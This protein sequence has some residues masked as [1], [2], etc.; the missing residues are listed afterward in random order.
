MVPALHRKRRTGAGALES[1]FAHELTHVAQDRYW[2]Q[3]ASVDEE[4]QLQVRLGDRDRRDL[5]PLGRVI[6]GHALYVHQQVDA[7]LGAFGGR[8]LHEPRPRADARLAAALL[9]PLTRP[10]RNAVYL[11]GLPFFAA[12]TR[13]GGPALAATAF[14]RERLPTVA[15]LRDPAAWLRQHH[16]TTT[17]TVPA[18]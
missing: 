12:L 4:E 10:I 1:L 18:R 5:H 14:S 8:Y 6:E 15:D 11:P 17:T 9:S 2:P 3:G 7:L 13:A 16:I